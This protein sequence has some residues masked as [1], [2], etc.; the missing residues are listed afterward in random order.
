MSKQRTKG[1]AQAKRQHEAGMPIVLLYTG[2][3][4]MPTSEFKVGALEYVNE[5]LAGVGK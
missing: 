4:A 3:R 5:K 1:Y 2:F